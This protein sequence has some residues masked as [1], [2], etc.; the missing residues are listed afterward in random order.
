MK[1][2]KPMSYILILGLFGELTVLPNHKGR[3][4]EHIEPRQHEEIRPLTYQIA[5]STVDIEVRQSWDVLLDP[6]F[7]PQI[8]PT[9]RE[10]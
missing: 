7:S 8:K 3:E 4:T 1:A 9:P 10:S 6:M 2:R 5:N